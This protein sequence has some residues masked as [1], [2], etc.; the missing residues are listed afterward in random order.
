MENFLENLK[1]KIEKIDFN[2][3]LADNARLSLAEY[4]VHDD[5]DEEL[6]F[7]KEVL[8]NP[9]GP[10][11]KNNEEGIYNFNEEKNLTNLDFGIRGMEEDISS[12]PIN[13]KN[14]GSG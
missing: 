7:T 12:I 6:D 5:F 11:I 10:V 13:G 4:Y 14:T 1:E 3:I 8:E 9:F 2:D